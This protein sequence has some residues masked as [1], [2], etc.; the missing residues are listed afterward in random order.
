MNTDAAGFAD[1]NAAELSRADFAVA[2]YKLINDTTEYDLDIA[3]LMGKWTYITELPKSD[4]GQ[5]VYNEDGTPVMTPV[6][7]CYALTDVVYCTAPV[8]AAVQKLD[9][10]VPEEYVNAVDN[11]DGTY[12]VTINEAGKFEREDGVTYTAAN[13][14]LSIRTPW[15]ATSRATHWC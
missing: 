6:Q 2:V 7:P 10:Y 12:T 4:K 9:I 13:A 14:P 15:T 5:F 3:S 11:G 1:E 8:D